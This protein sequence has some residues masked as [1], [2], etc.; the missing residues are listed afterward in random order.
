MEG[1]TSI[2]QGV[3]FTRR[4]FCDELLPALR[5]LGY[6][7]LVANLDQ[8]QVAE[9]AEEAMTNLEALASAGP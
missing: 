8:A 6:D 1:V 7:E 3:A 9:A 4:H 5:S 2:E